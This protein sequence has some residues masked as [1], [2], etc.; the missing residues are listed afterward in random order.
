MRH[1][2][3]IVLL[4]SGCATAQPGSSGKALPYAM[5]QPARVFELPTLLTEV[6]ALTD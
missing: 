3:F 1:L 4:S 6:S 5:R 2:L